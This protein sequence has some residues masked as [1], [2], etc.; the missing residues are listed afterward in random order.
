MEVLWPIS[1]ISI[2]T[3]VAAAGTAI[4][5]TWALLFIAFTLTRRLS[6][7]SLNAALAGL[8]TLGSPRARRII[9]G[10]TTVAMFIPKVRI[11]AAALG[12]ASNLN[13]SR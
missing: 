6:R 10:A 2:G 1:I 12:V 9:N 7:R 11:A 5:L 3:A 4:L 8:E 13:R